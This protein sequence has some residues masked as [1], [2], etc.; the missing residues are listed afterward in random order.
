MP[1][2]IWNDSYSV[3]VRSLDE[4]H[5]RLVAMSN[6]LH[7]AMSAGK[8]REVVE[9]VLKEMF[10]YTRLHFTTEEKLLE[11][12]NYPGL[13][14]QKREHEAFIKKVAEMQTDLKVRNLTLSIEVSHF[15]RSWI[16]NHIMG[17]DKQYTLFLN[18]KG[19]K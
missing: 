8:G 10:D 12:Y 3:G 13:S 7:E 11:K 9:P 14:D 19:E 6:Q 16:T 5:K 1:N 15:L 4:Q 2:I 17:I 18:S